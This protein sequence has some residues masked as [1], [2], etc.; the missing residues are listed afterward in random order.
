MAA[1]IELA[2]NGRPLDVGT[3]VP[4]FATSIGG[5]VQTID[6]QQYVVSPDSQR[7][8]MNTVTDEASTSRIT[9]I[10]NWKP[11]P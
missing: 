10:L 2:S 8:L 4:L 5:A 7:F 1:P 11:K 9:V 3:P 6:R